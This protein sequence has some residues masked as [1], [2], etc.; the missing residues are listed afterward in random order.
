M[1]WFTSWSSIGAYELTLIQ[2]KT[3]QKKHSRSTQSTPVTW[4]LKFHGSRL[5][6]AQ[7]K[8]PQMHTVALSGH[9]HQLLH[10]R[11]QLAVLPQQASTA[12]PEYSYT[13]YTLTFMCCCHSD[14]HLEVSLAM[15]PT[16]PRSD[17]NHK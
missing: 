5:G 8:I 14:T 9:Q 3:S 4:G 2:P 16:F 1:V 17:T 10:P 7:T 15:S 13:G 12:G 6:L 11:A